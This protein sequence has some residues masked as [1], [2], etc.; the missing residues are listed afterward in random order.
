MLYYYVFTGQHRKKALIYVC[1]YKF[2]QYA[3]GKCCHEYF[4]S[5][6]TKT[7]PIWKRKKINLHKSILLLLHPLL[8]LLLLLLFAK[9]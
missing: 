4:C 1:G 6:A 7:F 3:T 9:N 2:D 8:L 5:R